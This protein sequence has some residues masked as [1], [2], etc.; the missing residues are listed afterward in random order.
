MKSEAGRDFCYNEITHA[1]GTF[2]SC[3]FDTYSAMFECC[4]KT[5]PDSQYLE[6]D[7]KTNLSGGGDCTGDACYDNYTAA[8]KEVEIE[9]S[10]VVIKDDDDDILG[11]PL[12]VY[13]IVGPL[14][15]L[16]FAFIAIKTKCCRQPLCKKKIKDTQ[17]SLTET[18]D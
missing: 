16:I 2:D 5:Y 4:E 6:F 1:P 8:V 18:K 12:L 17:V 10:S 9:K 15:V 7:C 11:V 3:D 14:L 13:A